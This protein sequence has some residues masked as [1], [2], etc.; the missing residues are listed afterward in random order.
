[1]SFRVHLPL[2]RAQEFG[3]AAAD[4]QMGCIVKAYRE[5]QLCGDGDWLRE[6]WLGVRRALEFCWR[7]GGW[8]ADQD[9]V[10]EGCQ[11]NT[12]DVEYCGPNPQMGLWYLGALRAAEEMARHL[13]EGAFADQALWRRRAVARRGHRTQST[14]PSSLDH[15]GGSRGTPPNSK[16]PNVCNAYDAGAP[17]Q[18]RNVTQLKSMHFTTLEPRYAPTAG[19]IT[20]NPF[21]VGITNYAAL[22]YDG[23]DLPRAHTYA[24]PTSWKGT[25]LATMGQ[26]RP[27]LPRS[28]GP[29]VRCR[30][31]H[32]SG[33]AA[34]L[35]A[36]R[37]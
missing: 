1:M 35:P 28:W 24:T 29:V 21:G 17:G 34:G 2:D 3:R 27:F 22:D 36:G 15:L 16:A 10:M 14:R 18:G 7:E 30:P 9:G 12:M 5:W 8:Y 4:G 31:V 6:L 23:E 32:R 13:G 11:H 33:Q 37:L 20:A 25:S 19:S 26:N